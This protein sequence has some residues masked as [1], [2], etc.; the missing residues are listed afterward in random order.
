MKNAAKNIFFSIVEKIRCVF[1][2]NRVLYRYV[3]YGDEAMVC[4]TRTL[5]INGIYGSLI[6]VECYITNG[7]PAF[8][9]V[10]LPDNAV[11]EAKERVRSAIK[12][13]NITYPSSRI[14]VNLAP[15]DVKKTGAVYD[16]PVLLGILSAKGDIDKIS[17]KYAF[18]A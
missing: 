10:G 14:T 17:E 1:L 7:L 9:I 12:N 4:S 15:A 11:K 3:V 18:A 13:N 5:G 8:D 2:H 6:R 16:L